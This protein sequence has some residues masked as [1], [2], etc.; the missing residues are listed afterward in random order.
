MKN[1]LYICLLFL[2]SCNKPIGDCLDRSAEVTKSNRYRYPGGGYYTAITLSSGG[3]YVLPYP[4]NIH[5]G[6]LVYFDK[7]INC[8]R[9]VHSDNYK[10]ENAK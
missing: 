7:E 2:C 4:V 3:C 1:L 8:I 6:D 10:A 5:P 9:F